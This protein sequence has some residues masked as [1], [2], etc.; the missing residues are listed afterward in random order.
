MHICTYGLQNTVPKENL[1]QPNWFKVSDSQPHRSKQ[2]CTILKSKAWN[3][4]NSRTTDVR[5][6][7]NPYSTI[8]QVYTDKGHV[9]KDVDLFKLPKFI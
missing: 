1:Y 3:E 7:F 6:G 9:H 2:I 4:R 8:D 5:L